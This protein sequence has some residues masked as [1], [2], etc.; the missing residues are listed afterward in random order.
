[1]TSSLVDFSNDIAQTVERVGSFVIGVVEGGREGV[2]GI[3]WRPD[4]GVTAE[5]TIRGQEEVTVI[6]P[7]G[8]KA[9]ATI[10]GR[11]PGTDVAVLKLSGTPVSAPIADESQTRVGEVVLSVGRRSKEAWRR[12]T[13]LSAQ[14]ADLGAHGRAPGL[15]AGFASISFHS[16]ASPEGRS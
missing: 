5:H 8:E 15:T 6:L 14:S 4:L 2:S 13:E 7:S 3:L 11:D 9:K 12:L 16:L 10:A 1:M